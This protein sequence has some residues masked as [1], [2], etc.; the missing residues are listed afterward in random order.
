MWNWDLP[1]DVLNGPADA[2]PDG[3]YNF[4]ERPPYNNLAYGLVAVCVSLTI[5][6]ALLRAYTRLCVVKKVH[7]EDCMCQA[8]IT[9]V[10]SI[11]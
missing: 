2:S 4:D 5:A 3:I 1:S 9:F 10:N 7:V 11:V 8:T 6:G